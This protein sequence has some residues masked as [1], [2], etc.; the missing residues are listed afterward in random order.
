[1]QD[2]MIKKVRCSKEL[3][4]SITKAVEKTGATYPA[5]IREAVE[6]HIKRLCTTKERICTKKVVPQKTKERICTTKKVVPQKKTCTTKEQMFDPNRFS[7]NNWG[8]KK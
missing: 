4:E 1:M 2:G 6:E 8:K 3:E 7:K 5:F